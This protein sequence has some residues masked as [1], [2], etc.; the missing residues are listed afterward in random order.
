ML[1]GVVLPG[2]HQSADRDDRHE[3][4]HGSENDQHSEPP[5][6]RDLDRQQMSD[7]LGWF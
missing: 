7:S 2:P 6:C 1:R 3:Q 5:S 4:R